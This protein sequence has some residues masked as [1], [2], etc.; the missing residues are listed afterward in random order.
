MMIKKIPVANC[1]DDADAALFA[2]LG[3]TPLA[4]G[5]PMRVVEAAE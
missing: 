5:E 3:L 1:G 4:G 2:K